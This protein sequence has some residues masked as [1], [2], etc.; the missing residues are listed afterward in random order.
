MVYSKYNRCSGKRTRCHSG[1]FARDSVTC[2]G[3]IP[4]GPLVSSTIHCVRHLSLG[5]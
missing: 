3:C 1:I 4:F 5:I 2:D